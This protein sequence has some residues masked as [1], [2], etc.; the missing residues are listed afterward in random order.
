VVLKVLGPEA[1]ARQ[2]RSHPHTE[3]S[4]L[5]V[6]ELEYLTD[7]NRNHSRDLGP[8]MVSVLL[9]ATQEMMGSNLNLNNRQHV[10]LAV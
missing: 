3:D 9:S 5:K 1:R 2:N 6:F 7:L 8:S 10:G 4:V